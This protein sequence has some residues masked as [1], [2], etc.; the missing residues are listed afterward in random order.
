M[1]LKAGGA[2]VYVPGE[3][4]V[5]GITAREGV[6]EAVGALGG[7]PGTTVGEGVET[8]VE[9]VE[10]ALKGVPPAIIGEGVGTLWWKRQWDCWEEC[11][12]PQ[13]EKEWVKHSEKE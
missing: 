12:G 2:K 13:W 9:E 11:S 10:G 5:P 4:V 1:G 8:L 6:G 7:V 3:G